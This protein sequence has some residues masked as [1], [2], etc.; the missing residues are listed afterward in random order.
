ME[1]FNGSFVVSQPQIDA[2]KHMNWLKQ[3]E[4]AERQH[5]LF[6][7][8][9]GL[10]LETLQS[11]HDLFLLMYKVTDVKYTRQLRVGE[12]VRVVIKISKVKRSSLQFICYFYC[13]SELTTTFTWIMPFIQFS[14]NSVVERPDWVN[15]LIDE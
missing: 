11:H 13:E 12:T 9:L 7:E 2:G 5:F 8:N 1:E 10:G 3:L 6:R 4:E 14:T 15:D